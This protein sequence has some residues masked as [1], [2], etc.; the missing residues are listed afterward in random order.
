MALSTRSRNRSRGGRVRG[1]DALGV[2]RAVLRDVRD[3]RVHAVDDA[4][5][6]DGV[7]IFGVPVLLGGRL[8]RASTFCTAAS[9]RT[10]QP[11]SSSH[12]TT[13]ARCVAAQARVDQQGLGGAADAG[14]A[15]LGVHHDLARHGEIGIRGRTYTWQ[16]PSRCPMT[17]TRASLLHARH[18]ALA[19]ARHDHVDEFRHRRQQVP[20]CRAIGG[21]HEL[22][23]G[24]RQARGAQ[25]VDQAGMNRAARMR[26]LGAAA[27]D[28]CV[29]GLQAQRAR[30]AGHVGPALVNDADD[31]ERHAH[32]RDVA[33]RWAA[34]I[35]ATRCRWD[36]AARRCPRR[37]APWPRCAFRRAP[38]GRAWRR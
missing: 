25:P 30:I 33:A 22:D 29:A 8:T 21:R 7:E 28:G 36:R 4:R 12:C 13:G 24:G 27:Q 3:G 38:A 19:A 31:A 9:P 6:D 32:A 14:A 16:T 23:A 1:D 34:S 5:R 20:D 2:R 26:A 35:R 17:G 11:A 18:E 15:Q 37:R 10:S